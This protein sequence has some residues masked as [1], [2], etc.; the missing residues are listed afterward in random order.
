LEKE[1]KVMQTETADLGFIYDAKKQHYIV[2]NELVKYLQY[3]SARYDV[4]IVLFTIENFAVEEQLLHGTIIDKGGI[5]QAFVE[6]PSHIYNFA[7]HSTLNKIEKMRNLRKME[8]VTVINPINRFIQSI[9]FEMLT[10]LPGSDAFLLP[11][12]QLTDNVLKEYLTT[13]NRIFLLPDKM[14]QQPKAVEIQ[15]TNSHTYKIFVGKNSQMCDEEKLFPYIKKMING[16]KHVV[17]KGIEC[18]KTEEGPLEARVHLQKNRN[19]E[20]SA[21]KVIAKC[22]IFSRDVIFET[23]LNRIVNKLFSHEKKP[24]EETLVNTSLKIGRFLDFYIPFLGSC[25]LDYIFAKN[26][27]PYLIYVG[28]FEQNQSLYLQRNTNSKYKLVEQAFYYLLFVKR[29][30]VDEMDKRSE[31]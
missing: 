24:I 13:F 11:A 3:L 21:S 27:C 2:N 12:A 15:K 9:I 25:T 5:R 30:F 17:M 26:C 1:V 10:S 4:K 7:L 20:W 22:G 6:L 29:G 8:N 16:K 19:G 18:F 31:K 28:G 23:N 14:F